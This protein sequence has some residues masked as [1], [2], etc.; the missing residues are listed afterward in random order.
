MAVRARSAVY[1][2]LS[3][4]DALTELPNRIA[5]KNRVE[6]LQRQNLP[7]GLIVADLDHFKH[8]NDTYG[9]DAGDLLLKEFSRIANAETR[10]C[11]L[12]ARWGGEEFLIIC[13]TKEMEV[14]HAIAERIQKNMAIQ[15]FVLNDQV[16]K[17]TVSFGCACPY[18]SETFN[19]MFH[20]ADQALYNAKTNGRNCVM[21]AA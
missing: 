7:F 12:L 20:R 8:I 13:Q 1:E 14:I 21:K 11:D 3:Q 19:D 4:Q 15:S 10:D 5:L 18:E 2:Q 17:M 6:L 16:I 9:H